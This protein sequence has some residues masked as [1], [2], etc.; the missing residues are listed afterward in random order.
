MADKEFLERILSMLPEEFQNVYDDTIP[1]A[2]EIRKKMRDKN[3][4]SMHLAMLKKQMRGR[5]ALRQSFTLKDNANE[6]NESWLSNCRVELIF[7]KTII[8]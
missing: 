1:E 6:R 2:K 4:K 7:C 5:S 3:Y 8:K